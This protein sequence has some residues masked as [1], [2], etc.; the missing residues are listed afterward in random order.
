MFS[1]IVC[2][3]FEYLGTSL[4]SSEKGQNEIN[5][6]DYKTV[7]KILLYLSAEN[8]M[9]LFICLEQSVFHTG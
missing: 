6:S 2:C 3:F 8:E 9:F 7:N 4:C 5:S 1:C